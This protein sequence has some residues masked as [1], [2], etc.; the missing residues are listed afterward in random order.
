MEAETGCDDVMI[1]RAA[2]G[3]PWIFRDVLTARKGEIP[4]P[5]TQQ[6]KL[7]TILAHIDLHGE[8]YNEKVG[9]NRFKAHIVCYLK[10]LRGVRALRRHVCSEVHSLGDLRQSIKDF[11][12]VPIL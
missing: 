4:R 1:G 11:F 3:N 9:A 10:E 6:T 8:L 7:L 2:L 12:F 5:P